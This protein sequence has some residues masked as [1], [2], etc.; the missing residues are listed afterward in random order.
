MTKQTITADD[1]VELEVHHN[2]SSL[3]SELAALEKDVL[4]YEDKEASHILEDA[5][6][7][8]RSV[9]DWESAVTEAY[10]VKKDDGTWSYFHDDATVAAL[11]DSLEEIC[12]RLGVF[13]PRYRE[14][15]EHWIVSDCLADRLLARGEKVNKDFAGLT[16]WA[17]TNS[18]QLISADPVI[19]QIAKEWL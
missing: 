8:C 16:V 13:T 12:K 7:L 2:I 14:I 18:G 5:V 11:S 10:G 6:E 1:L 17:R 9:E 19:R 3:V 4:A 15:C